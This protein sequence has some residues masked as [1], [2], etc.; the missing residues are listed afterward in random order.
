[1][2]IINLFIKSLRPKNWLKNVFVFVPLVF[3]TQLFNMDKAIVTLIVFMAFCL[4]S[5]AV[6]VFNDI[7]DADKDVV[8]PEKCHRP[9]ASGMINK[10]HATVYVVLL[11]FS[12]L[13]VAFTANPTVCLFA[14]TYLVVN[15]FYTLVLKH[16]PV[17]DCFCIALGFVLRTFA[18][19]FACGEYVSD[20][21]FLT[22]VAMSLFMSF[23][24]RLGE[25]LKVD[26]SNQRAVLAHYN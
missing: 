6:Y 21:L 15:L 16:R 22:I 24:K 25:L 1:M 5:S 4:V 20:W 23:G 3:S 9:I 10:K 13:W 8:H 17:F 18:G 11:A 14:V 7:C 26:P 2:H 12:G 19:G